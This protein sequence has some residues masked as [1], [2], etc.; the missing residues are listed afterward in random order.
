MAGDHVSETIESTGSCLKMDLMLWVKWCYFIISVGLAFGFECGRSTCAPPRRHI[1]TS[2]NITPG[3][4]N[5]KNTWGDCRMPGS[6]I[7]HTVTSNSYFLQKRGDREPQ[8]SCSVVPSNNAKSTIN[9]TNLTMAKNKNGQLCGNKRSTRAA[10]SG[11]KSKNQKRKTMNSKK[12]Q[13][14]EFA[15]I[16]ADAQKAEGGPAK[17][18]GFKVSSNNKVSDSGNVD[19]SDSSDDEQQQQGSE[20]DGDGSSVFEPPVTTSNGDDVND[21]G[22]DDDDDN[23]NNGRGAED[24]N[25]ADKDDNNNDENATDANGGPNGRGSHTE[26]LVSA[27]P[28]NGTVIVQTNPPNGNTTTHALPFG[29]QSE[30]TSA[31]N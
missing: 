13:M 30:T 16:V 23:N 7:C 1:M 21:S 9:Q 10:A 31:D 12:P 5:D 6:R 8:S 24:E 26:N 4:L 11:N 19:L 2:L 17:R 20:Q 3:V 22:D 29:I 14:N 15:E 28:E 27:T 25:D 18:R